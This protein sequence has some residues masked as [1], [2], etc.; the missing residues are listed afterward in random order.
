MATTTTKQDERQQ[1]E[2]AHT[3]AWQLAKARKHLA[4]RTHD[5]GDWWVVMNEA[6]DFRVWRWIEKHY[7]GGW[8][9]FA[10][11]IDLGLRP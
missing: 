10:E 4:K 5:E 3:T 8:D 7:P 6:S 11:R 9:K 2:E 1:F